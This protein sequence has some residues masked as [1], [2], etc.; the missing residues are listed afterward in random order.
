MERMQD[1][2]CLA[3]KRAM[4]KS[5]DKLGEFDAL[6]QPLFDGVTGIID[7]ARLSAARSVNAT[8]TAAYW[9]AGMYVVEFER[10]G[11]RRADCG[12]NVVERLANALSVRYGRG[13]PLRSVRPMK[14]FRSARPILQTVSAESS[15]IGIASRFPLPRS[16]YVRLLSVRNTRARE[17]CEA[18]LFESGWSV[19]QLD[20]RI[21]SQFYERAALSKNKAA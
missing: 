10:R 3:T 5:I 2:R 18:R 6:F 11:N 12:G 8:M 9:L 16:A 7:S 21:D 4:G 17:F 1:R 15:L 20:R 13:F 14:A 19:R